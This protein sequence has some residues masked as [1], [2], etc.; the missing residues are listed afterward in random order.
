MTCSMVPP[1][2]VWSRTYPAPPF[3]EE[4]RV[5]V[6]RADEQRLELAALVLVDH[7]RHRDL[8]LLAERGHTDISQLG[9]RDLEIGVLDRE[10][11]HGLLELIDVVDGSRISL[12]RLDDVFKGI[13]L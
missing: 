7:H 10:R 13:D 11:V 1:S 12:H 5:S 6:N 3:Q 4:N 2:P 8:A 9:F